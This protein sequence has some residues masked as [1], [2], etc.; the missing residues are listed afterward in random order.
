M[1]QKYQ[2]VNG[3]KCQVDVNGHLLIKGEGV[4]ELPIASETQLGGVAPKNKIAGMEYNDV[5][6][7]GVGRLYAPQGDAY[8]L[9]VAT[10]TTL[11]GVKPNAKTDAMTASVGV[12]S[13]G[14]LY[15]QPVQ[16][17]QGPQG[18]QG[19]QGPKGDTGDTGA[20]GPK[21]DTGATG[22]QG[23]KGDTGDTGPTGPQGPQG[24]QGIQGVQGPAGPTGA[25]GSQG[26]KGD[27]GDT[28]PQGPK[29]DTGDTGPQG[30]KGDTGAGVAS[31]GTAGQIL[32]K[33]SGTDYDTEWI[34]AP[35]GG[36]GGACFEL[37]DTSL[38]TNNDGVYDSSG[39]QIRSGP[40]GPI[41]TNG[42]IKKY[43]DTIAV[44]TTMDIYGA[45]VPVGK[46][47]GIADLNLSYAQLKQLCPTAINA[48]EEFCSQ[49]QGRSWLKIW[50][51]PQTTIF[52]KGIICPRGY[53]QVRCMNLG[54]PSYEIMEQSYYFEFYQAVAGDPDI[55]SN[56]YNYWAIYDKYLIYQ[57]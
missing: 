34:N 53:I 50:A 29:G 10:P 18:E 9:P 7:D 25:T 19:P 37:E 57:E 30:P 40:L 43:N 35:S 54:T 48:F 4:Y 51:D 11:G 41:S 1:G 12:D 33:A 23:P 31:G 24:E 28:G 45:N 6:V 27:T 5:Y 21:G 55:S 32:A 38:Y 17:P 42:V 2:I 22:P 8:V 36:S 39:S 16:G 47:Q 52:N 15:V 44:G 56:G 26:P 49:N 13:E 20:T 3:A 46:C 14:K